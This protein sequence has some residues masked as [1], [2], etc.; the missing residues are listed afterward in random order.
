MYELL[1][2]EEFERDYKK[3]DKSVRDQIDKE[4]EQL[5]TNP[6]SGKP[7]GFNFFREKRARNYRIYYLIFEEKIVVFVVAISSKKN[8]QQ[9]I[10]K[11][12]HLLPI[13]KTEIEDRLNE[14]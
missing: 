12:K 10:D 6:F 8:Q 5:K 14:D 2:T 9:T 11:I 4:V 13:Y 1:T 7:L 3:L